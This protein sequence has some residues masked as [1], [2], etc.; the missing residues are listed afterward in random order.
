MAELVIQAIDTNLDMINQ[1]IHS[2]LD[3]LDYPP[4]FDFQLDL[5]VEE[6][7]VNIAHYAYAPDTGDVEIF[8]SVEKNKDGHSLL[9]I[10]FKDS[11]IPFNPLTRPDPNPAATLEE[12]GIGG[13]GIFLTK[14]YMDTVTYDHADGKNILTLT[15]QIG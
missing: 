4:T 9:T 13:W 3:G 14:K 2:Q 11:G 10:I 5:A 15:K 6:I 12:R 8:C 7:F 1:F